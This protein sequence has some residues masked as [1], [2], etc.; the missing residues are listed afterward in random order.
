[1]SLPGGNWKLR[2]FGGLESYAAYEG[3]IY[4][5]FVLV[6]CYWEGC[7]WGLVF[8]TFFFQEQ[9]RNEAKFLESPKGRKPTQL[10]WYN[11]FRTSTVYFQWPVLCLK[12]GWGS[13]WGWWCL[14][15]SYG[16][17]LGYI[18]YGWCL[19]SAN[20]ALMFLLSPHPLLQLD[21]E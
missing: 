4:K 11:S 18:Q 9:S 7:I 10:S 17:M 13:R 6:V 5:C 16:K 3:M 1:M 20:P 14:I 15:V 19:P 12:A 8:G 21:L 2:I